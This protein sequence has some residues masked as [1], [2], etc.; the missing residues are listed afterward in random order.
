MTTTTIDGHD[1]HVND[2][3][4]LTDYDEWDEDL[5]TALAA[6]DRDRADR[7]ALEAIRFLRG[8]YAAAG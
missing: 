1:V 2:E 5:A 8:D 7:R 3:G 6:P 4:F